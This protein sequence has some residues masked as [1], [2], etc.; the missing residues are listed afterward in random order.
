MPYK[1][2][3][4]EVIVQQESSTKSDVWSFAVC[5][6]EIYTDGR[7]PYIHMSNKQVRIIYTPS[8]KKR[9]P[10]E[11]SLLEKP[12][13]TPVVVVAF[14]GVKPKLKNVFLLS[15]GDELTKK[16]L[17][18]PAPTLGLEPESRIL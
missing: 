4:P 9:W 6:W 14:V 2:C 7:A 10:M 5:M 8:L 12:P 15:T 1:W 11:G 3:A 17:S 16:P 13:K 18:T